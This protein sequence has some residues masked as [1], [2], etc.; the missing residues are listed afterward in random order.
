MLVSRWI[1]VI[2]RLMGIL[3]RRAFA[4]DVPRRGTRFPRVCSTCP[5]QRRARATQRA[6]IVHAT[7]G[8]KREVAPPVGVYLRGHGHHYRTAQAVTHD[9]RR[10]AREVV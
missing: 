8:R 4:V 2:A 5:S 7:E 6:E 9:G 3:L 1:G 10:R